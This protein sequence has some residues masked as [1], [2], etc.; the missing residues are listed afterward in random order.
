VLGKML[1]WTGGQKP[2]REAPDRQNMPA[3]MNC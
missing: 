2:P 3:E 1:E